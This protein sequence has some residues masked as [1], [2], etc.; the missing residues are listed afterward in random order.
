MGGDAGGVVVREHLFAKCFLG[1][2]CFG[3]GT[4]TLTRILQ[5]VRQLER[6][7]DREWGES[8]WVG[9]ADR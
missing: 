5:M 2:R 7:G 8:G 1:K 9:P 6:K 3:S 4:L